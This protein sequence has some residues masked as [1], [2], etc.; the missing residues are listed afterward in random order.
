MGYQHPPHPRLWILRA[1]RSRS[2]HRRV[3]NAKNAFRRALMLPVWE[4]RK[5]KPWIPR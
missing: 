2:D 4:T 3:T 5:E 1:V